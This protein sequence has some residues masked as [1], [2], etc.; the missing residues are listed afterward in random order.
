MTKGLFLPLLVAALVFT[1]GQGEELWCYSCEN[2]RTAM[3]CE[4]MQKCAE[5]DSYCVTSVIHGESGEHRFSKGCSPRCSEHR[6]DVAHPTS[7]FTQCCRQSFC[8]TR[9]GGST[10]ARSSRTAVGVGVLASFLYVFQS[11][12]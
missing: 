11:G 2:E 10:G 6:V 5:S 4:H 8:N 3:N 12:L 7:I 9:S 1:E